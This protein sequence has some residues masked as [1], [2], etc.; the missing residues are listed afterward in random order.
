[1][2]TT[3]KAKTGKTAGAGARKRAT[4]AKGV[5]MKTETKT[6]SKS[7]SKPAA[8]AA[9][10]R[11]AKKVAPTKLNDRQLDLLK[12]VG[13]AGAA[14]YVAAKSPEQRSI[15]ALVERKLL[16]KGAK[17]KATGK[18]HYLLSKAGQKHVPAPAPAAPLPPAPEPVMTSA[19][20]PASQAPAPV[21]APPPAI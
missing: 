15:D 1:M 14:G 7:M 10:A 21:P 17:N 2:A 9:P 3:K 19:P 16:K 8:K 20:A 18:T 11:A 6:K 13:D 4:K 5:A 12:R